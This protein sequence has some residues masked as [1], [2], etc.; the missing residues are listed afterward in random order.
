MSAY[1][2]PYTFGLVVLCILVGVSLPASA[3]SVSVSGNG[4][5]GG[6]LDSISVT[7]GIF[8]ASS[9]PPDGPGVLGTGLVGVPMT[10]SFNPVAFGEPGPF[11]TE[12][13]IGNQS[14]D[15][16]V[17]GIIFTG[18][19]TVPAS[20]LATGIFTAPVE[21]VGQFM[22]FRDLGG[23]QGPLMASLSFTG[24]GTATL[25]IEDIGNGQFLIVYAVGDFANINGNLTVVPEPSSLL[26]IGTGLMALGSLAGRK[27][28]FL[29]WD[30][31]RF[32]GM[33]AYVRS[34]TFG[35]V[36][37]S[38]VLCVSLPAS[39]NGVSVTG[40]GYQGATADGLGLN[41]GIFSAF[42]AAPDG[43]GTLGSGMVGVPMTFS[44]SPFTFPGPDNTEVSIGNKFT[45]ILLGGII[46][47]T[48]TFSVP[49]SAL[50]TGTFT[51]P[52]NV[53]GQVMAFQDLGGGVQGPLMG[54]LS[55][56]GTG[57]VTLQLQDDGNGAFI[58]LSA[59]GNFQ[60]I[61]GNLTVVPEPS[62]LLLMGTGLMAMGSLA[63][64]KL[65]FLQRDRQRFRGTAI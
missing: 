44:F 22:A 43:P 41:A 60:N 39:A 6:T 57:T 46:F 28:G 53:V 14:T 61:N 38:I 11:F 8:S 59:Q 21:V 65:H 24:T 18:T 9:G 16:L 47:T 51:T 55:F 20:A 27:H 49:A 12:V 1:V 54:T 7:A 32:R 23:A 62:S 33:S 31:L 45:D 26:L 4:V 64:R 29:R 3:N 15:I 30:R 10:F 56:T 19:F 13:T 50:I 58:I 36:V 5:L 40:Y 37:L 63:R 42:S 25:H 34:C 35:L 2:R 17:G 52:V 48:G